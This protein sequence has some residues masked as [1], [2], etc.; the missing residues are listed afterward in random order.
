MSALRRLGN[1][2]KR[3]S[4]IAAFCKKDKGYDD[5][6]N[7]CLTIL[8]KSIPL[9]DA[10]DKNE[11]FGCVYLIKSGKFFKIGKTDHLGRRTYEL[12]IQLPES[13]E[14]VHKIQ[15]DDPIGIEKYW[16]NRFEQKR[17]RGEWFELKNEDIRAF[18]RRKFM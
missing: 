13:V 12:G 1:K 14:L 6:Y 18:K 8:P 2:E 15:T 9:D 4:K 17:K 5:V 7:I 11:K 16:H 10:K 3:V